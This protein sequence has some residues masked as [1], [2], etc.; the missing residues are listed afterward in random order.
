MLCEMITKICRHCNKSFKIKYERDAKYCSRACKYIST[1]KPKIPIKCKICGDV[2]YV[3]PCYEKRY[4]SCSKPECRH[5]RRSI[6]PQAFKNG[7][8]SSEET[9]K[10]QQQSIKKN[11]I[12]FPEKWER[13]KEKMRQAT[14]K[15]N[16]TN[17]P[18]W[19][20][21]TIKKRSRKVKEEGTYAGKK[22]PRYIN[23]D[24][25]IDGYKMYRIKAL[26]YYGVKCQVCGD[27]REVVLDVHHKDKNRKNCNIDNLMVLCKNCH[28][29]EHVRLNGG[30]KTKMF[31]CEVCGKEFRDSD[32]RNRRFCSKECYYEIYNVDSRKRDKSGRFTSGSNGNRGVKKEDNVKPSSTIHIIHGV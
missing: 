9:I 25:M 22:N 32:K 8:K 3:R 17:N 13:I 6:A 26:E 10:K 27:L 15:R 2:F 30:R 7:H 20:K 14:I 4:S 19:D 23:G 1:S 16:K 24:Y 29:V 31:V 18:S 11:K 5:K 12:K 28:V 21:E